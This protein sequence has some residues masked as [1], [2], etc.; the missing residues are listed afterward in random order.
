MLVK[1]FLYTLIALIALQSVDAI[2]DAV[3]YHQPNTP[4]TEADYF[5]NSSHADL[6]N[7]S[8]N[9]QDSTQKIEHHCCYCHGASATVL[10]ESNYNFHVMNLKG[11]LDIYQK[12]YHQEII[13]PDLR[14]PI[15]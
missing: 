8:T 4:Y 11:E 3:K 14:P 6:T 7:T 2:A 12:T 10:F 9:S 15:V 13:S 1:Y 5:P